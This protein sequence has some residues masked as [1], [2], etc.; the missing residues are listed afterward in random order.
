METAAQTAA[1]HKTA[2]RLQKDQIRAVILCPSPPHICIYKNDAIIAPANGLFNEFIREKQRGRG[3]SPHARA[4]GLFDGFQGLRHIQ[5]PNFNAH[6]QVN[7]QSKE[8]GEADGQRIA[9][10]AD[11]DI[12][13]DHI[14]IDLADDKG[15]K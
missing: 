11:A 8:N 9:E 12:E 7:D 15:V 13:A 14:N 10:A 3:I 6:G 1:I 2:S 4:V 5:T